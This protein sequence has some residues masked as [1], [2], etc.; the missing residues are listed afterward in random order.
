MA[1]VVGYLIAVTIAIPVM[2]FSA[3]LRRTAR[4]DPSFDLA[5]L[6][7]RHVS[8]LGGLAG[9]AVTGLVLLVTLSRNAADATGTTYTTV[10]AMFVV[11]YMGYYSASLMFTNVSDRHEG[12]GF[13]LPAAQYAAASIQLYFTLFVGWFALRPLFVTFHLNTMATLVGWLLVGTFIAGYTLLIT[14][15]YRTGYATLRVALL[16][17]ALGIAATGGYALV[18]GVLAPGL[19]SSELALWLTAF[20]FLP[21]GVAF[22]VSTWLPV[23]VGNKRIGQ[24]LEAHGHLLV[25]AYSQAVVTLLGFLLVSVL[26]VG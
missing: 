26:A 21:G 13:D 20:S 16:M 12:V 24:F 1:A 10:L 7:G 11:S 14:P 2:C 5:T 23:A 25:I 9:F 3:G 15:L 8:V 18:V 17:P 4:R 19:R 6:A 22:A